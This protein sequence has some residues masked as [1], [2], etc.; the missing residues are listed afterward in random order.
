ME[1]NLSIPKWP[2]NE[3]PRERLLEHGPEYLSEAELLAIVLRIGNR[4]KSAYDLARE[5]LINGQ[6]LSGLDAKTPAELCGITGIGKAKSAQIKAA[7]ELGK[8]LQSARQAERDCFRTSRE[9]FEY[10]KLK[11]RN[12]P[13]EQFM[14]LL[15]TVRNQLLKEKKLFEGSLHESMVDVREVIKLALNEQASGVI[16]V[17]NHPSGDPGPSKDDFNVTKKLQWACAAVEIRM[18]DHLIIGG[19]RFFSFADEGL[20]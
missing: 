1:Y 2:E 13:R 11:L 8:R 5:L 19:D 6:G 17:H 10:M 9:V 14:V 15:L 3:R 20:L 4:G 16:F 12:Q 18:H 7:L